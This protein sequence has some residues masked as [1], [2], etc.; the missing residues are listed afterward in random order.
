MENLLQRRMKLLLSLSD[1]P[2]P[3]TPDAVKRYHK[4]KLRSERLLFLAICPEADRLLLEKKDSPISLQD[5]ERITFLLGALGLSDFSNHL[6]MKHSDLLEQLA[7]NIEKELS[8]KH[9][10][11]QLEFDKTDQWE[12]DFCEQLPTETMKHY[13]RQLFY[14]DK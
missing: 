9:F 6:Q 4:E 5:F 13:I 7:T 11:L 12:K 1:L 14:I 10:N 3:I 8:E 2:E